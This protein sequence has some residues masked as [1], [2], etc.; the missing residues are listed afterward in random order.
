MA[1]TLYNHQYY[2]VS[3][4]D[5]IYKCYNKIMNEKF[6]NGLSIQIKTSSSYW[7]GKLNV[8]MR[9]IHDSL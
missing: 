4:T 7:T 9:G 3:M 5:T 6:I 8:L 1:S 2:L